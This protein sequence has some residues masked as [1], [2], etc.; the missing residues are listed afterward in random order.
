MASLKFCDDGVSQ[1][2]RCPQPGFLAGLVEPLKCACF[3][4]R[5][6]GRFGPDGSQDGFKIDRRIHR[7]RHLTQ[8]AEFFDGL[9]QLAS[10]SL[11]L[12]EQAHIF[13]CDHR[14]VSEG[15]YQFDLIGAK[16]AHL[17]TANRE[18]ANGLVFTQQ[19]YRENGPMTQPHGHGSTVRE[20]FG[21]R[22]QVMNMNRLAI[23][24]CAAG[25]PVSRERP[26]SEIHWD[27]SV[28]SSKDK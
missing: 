16:R 15:G 23:N 14:L 8:R 18:R 10:A 19:R 20:L 27:W 24:D 22:S 21:C 28:M 25:C 9:P 5:E 11:N 12:V 1:T 17:I 26:P 7:L 3:R 4:P 2:G 13:Y 6:R